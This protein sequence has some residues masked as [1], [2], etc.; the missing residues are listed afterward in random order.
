MSTS[1]RQLDANRQN[2]QLSTGPRT[3]EGKATSSQNAVK[4]GLTGRTMVFSPQE[5]LWYELHITNF[6]K[7]FA[8]VGHRERELVQRLA[9]TAWRLNRIPVLEQGIFALGRRSFADLYLEESDDNVRMLLIEQ[10]IY[11]TYARQ[12]NNLN[13]QESRLRRNYTKDLAELKAVQSERLAKEEAA[14]LAAAAETVAQQPEPAPKTATA[15]PNGFVFSTADSR[16]DEP[17]AQTNSDAKT[18]LTQS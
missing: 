9:D 18:A 16:S 2:A 5:A 13:I 4:T 7:D 14:R 1:E 8:P 17:T 12:L 15:T 3:P 10:H 11:L 6:E